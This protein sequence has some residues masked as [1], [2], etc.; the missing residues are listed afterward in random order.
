MATKRRRRRQRRELTEGQFWELMLGPPAPDREAFT[1]PYP[2]K[3]SAFESP[4]LR[5][6]AW[7]E[8][9]AEIMEGHNPGT[10]PWAWWEYEVGKQP[11]A[12]DSDVEAATLERLGKLE[13][14]ERAQLEA[15]KRLAKGRK[16]E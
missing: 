9:K 5:R 14:W 12:A 11:R 13:D 2:A 7:N 3:R 10:R 16:R 1:S 8:H 15:L 4:F 6:A